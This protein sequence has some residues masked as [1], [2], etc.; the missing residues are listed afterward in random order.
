M[1]D[2]CRHCDFEATVDVNRVERADGGIDFAADVR[3]TCTRCRKPMQFLGLPLG[4]NMRGAATSPDGLQARLAMVPQG[5]TPHPLAAMGF[6][7]RGPRPAGG[8]H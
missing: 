3:V 2:D 6:E 5:D 4:L 7:I 1:I 8:T